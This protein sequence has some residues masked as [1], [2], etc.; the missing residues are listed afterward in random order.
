[1]K[2]IATLGPKTTNK[3]VIKQLIDVGVD[4][5]R[6]N[7]SHFYENQFNNMISIIRSI[8]KD[9][10][11][12]ADLQGK[13]VRVDESLKNV[14]KIYENEI[15]YFC[16]YDGYFIFDEN[17]KKTKLIPLNIS[18]EIISNNNIEKISMKDGTMNFKVI[19][20]NNG[21]LK[22]RVINDG[23]IRGGKGCN[24]PGIYF[25]NKELTKKDKKSLKWAIENNIKIISQ[26]FV[27]NK[28]DIDHIRKYI[29]EINGDLK[30][31]KL[32]SKIETNLGVDNFKE[33]INTL[34]KYDDLEI[35]IIGTWIWI[36]GNTKTIKETLKELNFRWHKTKKLWFFNPTGIYKRSRKNYQLDEIRE[37]YGSKKIKKENKEKIKIG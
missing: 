14:F 13:K 5:F 10:D 27:E 15:V 8:D 35:E 23:I 22:V 24:I 19:D 21:F 25:E 37:K 2:I 29:C 11:I 34:I 32:L 20:Q 31:I 33:I 3:E 36:G 17:N 1:M 7:F 16:G 26:S 9:M 12:M 4:I 30:S 6:L 18:S 28:R